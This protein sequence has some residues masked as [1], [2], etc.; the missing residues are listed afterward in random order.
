M[1]LTDNVVGVFGAGDGNEELVSHPDRPDVIVSCGGLDVVLAIR[2]DV[3]CRA[4]LRG[5]I[6]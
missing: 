1:M 5:V 2:G 6:L 3:R 4:D